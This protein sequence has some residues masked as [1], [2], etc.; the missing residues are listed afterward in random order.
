MH[1]NRIKKISWFATFALILLFS[2]QTN[3]TEHFH[4]FIDVETNY[5]V[6]QNQRLHTIDVSWLYDERMSALMKIQTPNLTKL[7]KKTLNELSKS[8][9][10]LTVNINGQPVKT[11]VVKDYQINEI[12]DHGKKLLQLDFTLPLAHPI[13]LKGKNTLTWSF[14]DPTGTAI[15]LYS[16]LSGIRI[17]TEPL[18]S[19]CIPT[20]K[21]N[22]DT[23]HGDPAQYLTLYC[24]L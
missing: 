18:K 21:G 3:A 8:H 16:G 10:F 4:Y 11:G 24:S 17:M 19:G 9:Y 15:L 14:A 23:Q 6:D 12:N 20:I 2:Q 1:L 22:E 7:G 5:S 13:P